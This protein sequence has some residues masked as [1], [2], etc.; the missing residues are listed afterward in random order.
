M[1]SVLP[2]LLSPQ[3]LVEGAPFQPQPGHLRPA[4]EKLPPPPAEPVGFPEREASTGTGTG[5]GG[6]WRV[7]RGTCEAGMGFAWEL[8]EQGPQRLPQLTG[9]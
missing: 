9:Q 7:P 4:E 1:T 3:S 8:G 5:L 6:F 2:A